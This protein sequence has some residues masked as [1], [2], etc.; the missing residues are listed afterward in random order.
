[1]SFNILVSSL[2]IFFGALFLV[3]ALRTTFKIKENVPEEVKKRW[4]ISSG[5][6]IFFLAGYL[7][8]IIVLILE[9]KI[10]LEIITGIIFFG[11]GLFVYII[12]ALARI[13]I[14]TI[15]EKEVDLWLSREKLRKRAEERQSITKIVDKEDLDL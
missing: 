13:T 4:M 15:E 3:F 2:F 1:M 10:S 7:L 5:L 12:I 14:M 8:S 9:V 11:G 6:M